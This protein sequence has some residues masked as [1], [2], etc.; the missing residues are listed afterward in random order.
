MAQPVRLAR[1]ALDVGAMLRHRFLGVAPRSPEL[2]DRGRVVFQPAIGVEQTAVRRG[3]DQRAGIV[4]AVDLHQR[5][6]ERL[7]GLH[8]DRLV[9]DEGAG[10]AVGELHAAQDQRL[11]GG[12]VA[13]DSSFRAGCFGGS[14]NMAVTWPC[15]TPWRTSVASPRAPSASAKASSRIDLPAPVSPV[16]TDKPRREVEV[17]PVDQHDVAD[18]KPGEHAASLKGS[19]VRIRQRPPP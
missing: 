18:R 16:S 13:S 1:G 15:S 12:D 7:Q 19:A 4:L 5:R 17:E 6:A 9:V 8:A 14:S 10:A 3:V 2:L 11:V